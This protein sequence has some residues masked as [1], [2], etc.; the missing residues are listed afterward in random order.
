MDRVAHGPSVDP[1][2]SSRFWTIQMYPS[3]GD[4]DLEY[5]IWSTQITELITVNATLSIACSNTQAV[6][7]WWRRRPDL[8][9]NP[10]RALAALVA[11]PRSIKH[12]S[13]NNGRVYFQ[14]PL[15]SATFF[16]LHKP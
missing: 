8:T 9:S 11:G 14:T 7:S 12:F 10:D 13:T 15:T 6:V 4:P 2:N 16:R 1:T 5:W 3:D